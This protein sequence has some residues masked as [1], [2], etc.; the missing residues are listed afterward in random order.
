MNEVVQSLLEHRSIRQYTEEPISRE[1]LEA[2]IDAAQAAPS[3]INGQQ[4]SIVGVDE[5]GLK[6]KLAELTGNQKW[7]DEAPLF[8]V[9]CADY[10]RAAIAAEK[11]NE[12]LV[13]T[14]G[15]EA[16]LVGATDVGLSMGYAIAAAESMGLGTVPI[17]GIRRMPLEVIELL[18]LPKYV[19]PV[20][21]LVI[22]HPAD[23]SAKKPRLP[24]EAVYHG[25]RYSTDQQ[26]L[27]DQY[28][29]T[30]RN[31]LQQRGA[32]DR[33][34]TSS[35]AGIYNRVYYPQV[36]SMLEQQGFDFK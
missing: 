32:Q 4:V 5:A 17:G 33:T 35:I 18:N 14:E 11:N 8:L 20:C 19:F 22:G 26:T 36:R 25:N 1:Q 21:G 10:H 24:R 7:V 27:I 6:R 34:W 15:I 3:S 2:I 16:S 23:R 30:Y 13:I 28:D 31:Y 12:N 9:F 29:E